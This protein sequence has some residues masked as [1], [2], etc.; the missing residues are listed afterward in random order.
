M[1]EH[2]IEKITTVAC[3]LGLSACAEHVRKIVL[4]YFPKHVLF[5]YDNPVSFCKPI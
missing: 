3:T 4:L 2:I 5:G 1:F